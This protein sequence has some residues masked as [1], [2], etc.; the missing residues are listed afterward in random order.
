MTEEQKLKM[1]ILELCKCDISLAEKAYK[2]VIGD[3][4]D[5][6]PTSAAD[7]VTLKEDGV[8]LHYSDEHEEWFDG[9]NKI[10]N[11]YGVAVRYGGNYTCI[12]IRDVWYFD[13]K[14]KVIDKFSLLKHND[15]DTLEDENGYITSTLNAYND[16]DG[17]KRTE[18]LAQRGCGIPIDEDKYIPSIGEWLLVFKFLDKVQEALEYIEGEKLKDDWYWSSTEYLLNIAWYVDI[19]TGFFGKYGDMVQTCR[20]RCCLKTHQHE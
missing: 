7:I 18:R 14:N 16:F 15:Y 17:K 3:E 8:Y 10:K 1:S 9:K 12:A 5:N 11:V 2:F 19:D 20:V 4:C 13:D 6:V